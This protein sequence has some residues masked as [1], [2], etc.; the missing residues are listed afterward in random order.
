PGLDL[1]MVDRWAPAR[2]G[3]PDWEV[4]E[5][6]ARAR[7]EDRRWHKTVALRNT[8]FAARRRTVL[9]A[10]SAEGAA[11]FADSSLDFVFI[12]ASH[13]Y[14]AVLDDL[15]AW[16]PKV[17]PGGAMTGDDID[18]PATATTP[19]AKFWDVRGA[20][21]AFAEETGPIDLW[22]GPDCI[23]GYRKG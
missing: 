17:R 8:A 22:I 14:Q 19:S 13:L 15:R 20:L 21:V 11:G 10:D 23:W 12:D 18:R 6:G 5:E 4:D 7:P 1:L 9:E 3:D 16:A 2:P